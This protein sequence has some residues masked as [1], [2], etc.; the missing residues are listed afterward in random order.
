MNPTYL[1]DIIR[2]LEVGLNN[3]CAISIIDGTSGAGAGTF[4]QIAAADR[5]IG[6]LQAHGIVRELGTGVYGCQGPLRFGNATGS[7]SSWFE[8]SNA[9][10]VFESR[11]FRTTLYK[12][13]ITDNGT[14]TTTFILENCALIAPTGVGASFDSL[15]DTDVTAVTVTGTRIDGFTGGV[16]IGGGAG[17]IF[18]NCIFSNG[19]AISVT[20][21]PVDLSDS[22]VLTP[23]VAADA[24]ALVWNVNTDTNGYLDSMSFTKGTNAHHAIELGTTSPIEVTFNGISFTGFNASNEQNDSSLYLADRGSDTTWT[25]NITGGGAAPSYKRARGGDT[26]NIVS[27]VNVTVTVLNQAGAALPGV[28]VA[29]FQGNTARTVILASTPTD[30]NGQVSTTAAQNLSGGLII[31]A[32]QSTDTLSFRTREDASDGITAAS[33]IINTLTDHHFQVGDAVVYSK[34]GGSAVIGLTDGNTYYTSNASPADANSVKLYTS[35]ALAIADG[36]PVPL[37]A[38]AADETHTLDPQRYV[39]ASATAAVGTSDVAVQV[40]M[41]TDGIATG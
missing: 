28:E 27:S 32:R 5:A 26:V 30:D 18:T 33:D 41:I 22:S 35:A 3:G 1:V 21:Q 16:G 15:T 17:Q 6:D 7:N 31:R 29:I 11:G 23:T 13:F 34:Q 40:T 20:S 25:I 36:T 19:G 9:T 4:A 37:S 38:D 24:S 8:D 12:I 39:A 2:A 14:G 10:L